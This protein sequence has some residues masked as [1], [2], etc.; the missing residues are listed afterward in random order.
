[1][2]PPVI[3]TRRLT[4]R[5]VTLH[6][7]D[8]IT[9][10]MRHWD[11]VQWLTAPTFPYARTDAVYFV[12]QIIPSVTNWAIDAGEGLIGMIGVKPDLGYWLHRDFHGQH[13][14]SEAAEAVTGRY[15][16]Q[17]SDDLVSGHYPNNHASRKVLQ[18]LGFVDVGFADQVQTATQEVVTVQRM[19]LTKV[20]W[21]ARH[22]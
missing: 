14:M 7:V 22:G 9:D 3:A 19:A 10:A 8:A 18:R 4:L 20:A 2:T 12:T 16:D 11:V 6:D 1:V 15:F 5:P 21:G 17:S 13:I